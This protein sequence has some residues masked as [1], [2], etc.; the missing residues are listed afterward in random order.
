MLTH[1]NEHLG[2]YSH[3]EEH[4]EF[5]IQVLDG[6]SGCNRRRIDVFR[7]YAADASHSSHARGRS[8]QRDD[9]GLWEARLPRNSAGANRGRL[10]VV[11]L[12]KAILD[13]SVDEDLLVDASNALQIADIERR[14]KAERRSSSRLP[15]PVNAIPIFCANKY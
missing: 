13:I 6:P 11:E 1:N 3:K 2:V 5:Q 10:A 12:G 9:R 14:S 4:H 7:G 8:S 15:K